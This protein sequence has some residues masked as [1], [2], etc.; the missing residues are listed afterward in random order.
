M[1]DQIE[2][3]IN[4]VPL[5]PALEKPICPDTSHIIREEFQKIIG[6]DEFPISIAQNLVNNQIENEY[7]LQCGFEAL[8]VI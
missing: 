8:N 1:E 2:K 4:P 6:T 5:I 3:M 7:L